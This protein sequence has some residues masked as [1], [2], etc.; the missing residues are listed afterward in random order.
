MLCLHHSSGHRSKSDCS[1]RLRQALDAK[2]A[3]DDQLTNI[4]KS[5]NS[6]LFL[7]SDSVTF[8]LLISGFPIS[9]RLLRIIGQLCFYFDGDRS[10]LSYMPAKL[11]ATFLTELFLSSYT[12]T[13]LSFRMILPFL[14][15]MHIQLFDNTQSL[16]VYAAYPFRPIL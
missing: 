9:Y 14:H 10:N 12:R 2:N 5:T 8:T 6:L 13:H 1:I 3:L 4:P 15:N 11:L 7:I 16:F